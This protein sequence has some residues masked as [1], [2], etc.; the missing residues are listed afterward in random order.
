MQQII[1]PRCFYCELPVN[2]QQDAFCPHCH[3]PASPAKEEEYLVAA[4]ASLQQAI[5]YGGLQLKVVDLFQRYQ[6]RLRMLQKQKAAPISP[7]F[8]TASAPGV[9]APSSAVATGTR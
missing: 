4:L 6:N 3:Y 8:A 2:P 7:S 5:S 1:T 9:A